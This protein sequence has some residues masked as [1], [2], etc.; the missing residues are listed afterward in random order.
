[1]FGEPHIFKQI[2]ANAIFL[3]EAIARPIIEGLAKAQLINQNHEKE[4]VQR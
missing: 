1:M 3:G 4:P 2:P